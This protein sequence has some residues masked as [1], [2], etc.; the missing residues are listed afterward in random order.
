MTNEE[1][2]HQARAAAFAFL[3]S[4]SRQLGGIVR[5]EDV[6]RFEFRGEKMSLL[7]PQR[8]IRKPR[9]LS[10]ALSVRTVYAVDPSSRP[11]EDEIGDDGYLRYKWRGID[12]EHSENRAL[13]EALNQRL[14]LIWFQ[15]VA[16]GVYVPIY[17]VW[18]VAE[19]RSEHQFVVAL[20]ERQLQSWERDSPTTVAELALRYGQRLVKERMHQPVFRARVLVAYQGQCALCLLRHM[21]LLDAAHIRADAEGGLPVV[22]NGIA[23]CKI[24][25][26]AF[27]VHIIGIRPD[28]VIQVRKD[29]LVEPDGPTLRHAIQ[30]LHNERIVVP[31]K[32]TARPDPQLLDERFESFL[33]A[34]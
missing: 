23:M 15:G 29:V 13:R 1:P 19:E 3:D 11:Y 12:G 33:R 16:A 34:G 9:Q 8:G 28:H 6:A 32:R 2:E 17:P 24:H 31:I 14:P 30:A 22:P 20:D 27:D 18:L 25:H 7:D 10:A 26:A 4:V 5:F 21:E